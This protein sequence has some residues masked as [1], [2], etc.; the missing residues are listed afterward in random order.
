MFRDLA[1]L[2]EILTGQCILNLLKCQQV[3]AHIGQGM[4]AQAGRE[5]NNRPGSHPER[6]R[7]AIEYSFQRLPVAEKNP[8]NLRK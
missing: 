3:V 1:S 7:L 2:I 5:M 4:F 8:P 6:S